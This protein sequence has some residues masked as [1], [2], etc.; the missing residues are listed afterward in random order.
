MTFFAKLGGRGR[1]NESLGREKALDGQPFAIT[2]KGAQG[3][4]TLNQDFQISFLVLQ[5]TSCGM[6]GKSHTS[7]GT[8]F[9]LVKTK[10]IT[11]A[12]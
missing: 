8:L 10:I 1:C 9:A 5:F 3:Q 6:W 7:L 12:Y 11:P 4:R 2:T